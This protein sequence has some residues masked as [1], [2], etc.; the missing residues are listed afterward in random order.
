MPVR[1]RRNRPFKPL[2]ANVILF[3]VVLLTAC[4]QK[5]FAPASAS[6]EVVAGVKEPVISLNGAWKFTTTPPP[7]FWR[8]EVSPDSWPAIEV[9]GECLMQGFKIQHDVAYPYKRKIDIP[10]DFTGQRMLLRFDGVYSYARVWVNGRP[11]RDHHGGFTS[12]DCDITDFV[13]P[14]ASAWLTVEITDRL[15]D[16]SYGSGYAHHLIGGILRDVWL[17]ALPPDHISHVRVE[18][19]WEPG[20]RAA[21]LKIAAGAAFRGVG[22]GR[23]LFSLFDRDGRRVHFTP[24]TM[25]LT[26]SQPAGEILCS[27]KAP[28]PW[29]AEHPNLYSLVTCLKV[30]RKT[31]QESRQR[32]GFRKVEVAGNR[33]LVNGR[34][35]KLRGACR[36]DVHPLLGRR[37]T[38]DLD[39]RDVLL[40][41]E[42]NIN[43]IRTSH[44][45]PSQAFLEF[46]DEYGIYVEEETAVCFVGTH[47]LLPE[48]HKVSFTQDD[49]AFTERYLGQLREMVARDRNHPSVI[50]WSIGNENLYGTNFQK[51]Y[52]WVKEADPTRPVIF[53]YPGKVPA[54]VRSTDILSLH[55]PSYAGD[56]EQYGVRA[57]GFSCGDAPV[58]FDEWAHVP[59]YNATTL[60]EDP[61]VRNFWGESLKAFWDGAFE[62]EAVGGAIWG[63][64]DDVFMLPGACV[65]YGEWGIVDGWRRRKPEFWHV[66]KAY[67]PVRLLATSIESAAAGQPLGIPVANRFDHTTLDE[68]TLRWTW[69]GKSGTAPLPGVPPHGRGE[70]RLPAEGWRTGDS[71]LLQF[72]LGRRFI[73][74]ELISLGAGAEPKVVSSDQNK[75]DLTVE[76]TA[77]GWLVSAGAR[78]YRISRRSGLIDGV[79]DGGASLLTGGPYIYLRTLE[80]QEA[81]NQYRFSEVD[82]KSWTLEKVELERMGVGV[83]VRT[84]GRAGRLPVRFHSIIGADGSL[85]VD[86]ELGSTPAG[87]PMGLGLSFDLGEPAW[88]EWRRN[89]LWSTYPDGHIGRPAGYVPLGPGATESYRK[90]PKGGW[91]TDA[92]DFFLQGVNPPSENSGLLSNDSRSLKENILRLTI[93]FEDGAGRLSVVADGDQAARFEALPGGGQR[94]L[95]LTAW[96]Y[97]DIDWGNL[98]RPFTI[99]DHT[100]GRIRLRCD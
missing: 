100:R 39:R 85:T 9:P 29:D 92:W 27:I 36:H 58:I 16:I 61:N 19:D 55:Y 77:G 42:A 15:D 26:D 48:Y 37:T 25:D 41:R 73:D 99:A 7:E 56:L 74:E 3:F 63:M 11:V 76:K 79:S 93:G 75:G 13:S 24:S 28:L 23:L 53:S 46:C 87:R 90:Q 69:L 82:P 6:A 66:K 4:S 32:I 14:G 12:W 52:D 51:E 34:P 62:S 30:G 67:S 71:I 40:A 59:C 21:A 44:Y 10:A 8:N 98:S 20:S 45:P 83:E 57:K 64:I 88:L 80:A 49:P 31:V 18:T 84:S 5:H 97:P 91:Q 54:G 94:L 35:V 95:I 68:L 22:R 1:P 2:Y 78:A 70:I 50:I 96:D 17:V 86:F 43:F 60:V 33:L 38:R 47:R 65:G 81:W 72:F 89:G